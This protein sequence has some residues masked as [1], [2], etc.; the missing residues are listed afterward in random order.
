MRD[1]AI[2]VASRASVPERP[3]MWRFLRDE[4]GW[5]IVSSW[6]DEAGEGETADLGELWARIDAEIRGCDGL[7]LYAE[8]DDFPL[9]GALVEAGIAIGAGKPV[10]IV[11][12]DPSILDPRSFR[13]L[14]SWVKHPRCRLCGSLDEARAWIGERA[15]ETPPQDHAVCSG[16]N[17]M[18]RLL[19]GS[20]G[21]AVFGCK[22]N[23]G[24][25]P[26]GPVTV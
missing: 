3:A 1:P 14:G 24:L 9:K 7:I 19:P 4:Q 12:R 11:L 15:V 25:P 20:R 16:C 26:S 13:P 5:R 22:C 18:G 23:A 21:L 8:T 10:A 17:Y 6:I 2:Y